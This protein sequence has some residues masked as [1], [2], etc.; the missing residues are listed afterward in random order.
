MYISTCIY[1]YALLSMWLLCF[2]EQTT[3][4]LNFLAKLISGAGWSLMFHIYVLLQNHTMMRI[5]LFPILQTSLERK[6]NPVSAM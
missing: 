3:L 1:L 5:F 2:I 6:G 4:F